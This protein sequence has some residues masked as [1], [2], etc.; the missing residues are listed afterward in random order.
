MR[1]PIERQLPP[2][3]E[4]LNERR[5]RWAGEALAAFEFHGERPH[6][7]A[8]QVERYELEW[9]NMSDLLADFGHFCDRAGID[10]Q[11]ILRNAAL[12]YEEET[13]G[14]GIQFTRERRL[15]TLWRAVPAKSAGLEPSL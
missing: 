9:Q 6:P 13:D 7:N 14:E 3:P 2:D 1:N 5:A 15:E 4:G 11:E 10:L 12:Q 8:M